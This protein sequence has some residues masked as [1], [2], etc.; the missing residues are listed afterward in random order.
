MTPVLLIRHGATAW[1][2]AGRLQGRADIGLSAAGRAEVAGWRLPPA[3]DGARWL[4]EPAAPGARDRGAA[5]R[6]RGAG[7]AAA[8]RDGLG[9]LGGPPGGRAAAPAGARRRGGP[10]ARPQAARRREPARGRGPPRERSRPSSPRDPTPVVAVCHKG[11]IRAALALAT[12]WDMRSPAAAATAARRGAGARSASRAAVCSSQPP[13]LRAGGLSHAGAVLGPAPAR[14]RPSEARRRPLPS[15][16]A[17]H[18]LEVD[19]GE[20]RAARA[21]AAAARASRLIQ[22]P[23]VQARDLAF[24]ALVDEARPAARR[25]V[26]GGARGNACCRVRGAGAAGGDHRDVPVRPARLPVR[27]DAA[28]RGR[29]AEPAAAVAA[30][31]VRDILVTKPAPERYAWMRDLALAHYDRVLVHTDPA[32]VPFGLTFPYADALGRRLVSTGYVVEPRAAAAWP[33]T[34]C[35]SRPAADGSA[36]RCSR[37]RSRRAPLIAAAPAAVA[38]DRRRRQRPRPA[39]AARRGP[40]GRAWLWSSSATIS[41]RCW[42]R[43]FSLSRRR[44]TTRWWRS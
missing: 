7:R 44:A 29:G 8:D 36:A 13:P 4:V 15:A 30:A 23:A 25:R 40:A 31:S 32:L 6:A 20:R 19:A 35:W 38:A 33:A 21:L 2:A 12:G 37:P 10:R 3:W 42:R 41:R 14:Q 16:L 39:R 18:G 5:G 9:R 24:S 1:N 27:A 43:A 26:A 28:A 34:R 11:V 22:L 17:G